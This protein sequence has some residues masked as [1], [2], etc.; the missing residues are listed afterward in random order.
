MFRALWIVIAVRALAGSAVAGPSRTNS[1]VGKLEL[2]PAPERPALATKGFLDRS[3][4]PLAPVRDVDVTRDMFV[5]LD[6]G[7]TPV[8]PPQVNWELIGE[9]F[10][11]PVVAAPTGAE[12]VI[13]DTTKVART[14]VAA[15][16]AKLV[17]AGPINPGGT[18]SFRVTEAGKVYTIGDRDAAYLRGVVVV[19][20]TQ[21]IG[22]PD[23]SGHFEVN[24]VPPG[25]YKL[26]VWY[27]DHWLDG[28]GGDVVVTKG[29]T[30]V[31][32]KI[33]PGAFAPKK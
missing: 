17:P 21:L 22:Y 5:I 6:G 27:R 14:L 11:R 8:S 29:K 20:N 2:P 30:E 32:P 4:N 1:V 16:D 3:E 18:R 7:D 12:V 15:E 9:S 13:K 33:P 28:V 26:R 31:N 19:V 25:S 23:E 10:A 24:D